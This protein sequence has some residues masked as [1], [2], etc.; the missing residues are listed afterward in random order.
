MTRRSRISQTPQDPAARR[1]EGTLLIQGLPRT[2]K[3]PFK[4][5]CAKNGETMRDAVI[6]FMRDYTKRTEKR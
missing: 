3:N 2:T 4:A 5:A 6:Q 1:H